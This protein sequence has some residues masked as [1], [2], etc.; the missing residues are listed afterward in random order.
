MPSWSLSSL[1]NSARSVEAPEAPAEVPP[2]ELLPLPRVEELEPEVP[3]A[4]DDEEGEDELLPCDM[5]G[6]LL[7]PLEDLSDEPAA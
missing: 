1:S 6:E 5:D 7:E 3:P 4:D 2:D